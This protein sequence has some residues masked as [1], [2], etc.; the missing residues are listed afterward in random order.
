MRRDTQSLTP[1]IEVTG[2]ARLYRAAGLGVNLLLSQSTPES[3][4]NIN[5]PIVS[6]N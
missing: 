6:A 2:T 3:S 5:D 4:R 1:N